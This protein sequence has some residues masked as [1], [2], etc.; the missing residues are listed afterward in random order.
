MRTVIFKTSCKISL[1]FCFSLATFS[2]TGIISTPLN[3]RLRGRPA[4]WSW[5]LPRR[6]R[7]AHPTRSPT[8]SPSRPRPSCCET[9]S[10]SGRCRRRGP[11]GP[12]GRFRLPRRRIRRTAGLRG[13]DASSG[14]ASGRGR[15]RRLGRRLCRRSRCSG[16]ASRR[17]R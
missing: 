3:L 4:G 7:S 1:S 16:R 6:R 9:S 12:F 10:S 11:P 8:R 17:T 14:A 13:R 15:R 5:R 2:C